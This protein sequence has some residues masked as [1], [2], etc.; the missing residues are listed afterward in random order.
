MRVA[1]SP[2]YSIDLVSHHQFPMQKYQA[3]HATLLA[4]G[5]LRADEVLEPQPASLELLRLAHT[6]EYVQRFI[7]GELT[8]A[9]QRLLGFPWSPELVRRALFATGGTVLAAQ[10]ALAEGLAANLAGG[11]HHAFADHGEGYCAFNDLAVAVRYLQ[12][13]GSVRRVAVIDC[14]VH[15]GNGTAAILGTDPGVFTFSIHCESNYPRQKV[16]GSRDVGLRDGVED[17]EYLTILNRELELIWA[18]FRP[19]LV[20]YQAG[21]DPLAGDRLGRLRLTREGLR[22]RDELVLKRCVSSSVPAVVVLGGGYGRT[23][24]ETV[25]A[26]VQTVATA[27]RITGQGTW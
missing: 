11:S 4:R 19:E 6:P 20:L 21:V 24:E 27:K 23:L 25:D 7:Q 15:Q 18:E 2:H 26:H 22:R 10:W 13:S 14:D 5:L 3:V 16:C 17:H 8:P 12:Q 9:E 1:F